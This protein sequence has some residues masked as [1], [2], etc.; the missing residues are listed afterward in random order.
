MSFPFLKK[1]PPEHTG[2][3]GAARSLF[4][5]IFLWFWLA[6][7]LSSV[8]I[9][10]LTVTAQ[11]GPIARFHKMI[12]SHRDRLVS[13]ALLM[14]GESAIEA[15]SRG[16]SPALRAMAAKVESSSGIRLYIFEGGGKALYG[17]G[18][19][20][21]K[22]EEA[23]AGLAARVFSLSHANGRMRTPRMSTPRMRTEVWHGRFLAALPFT[24]ENQAGHEYVIAAEWPYVPF[25]IFIKSRPI[26]PFL[27][28]F[29][30]MIYLI[31]GGGIC[32]VLA[33]QLT[34]PIRRLRQATQRLAAGDLKA[35]VGR[36]A[37]AAKKGDEIAALGRDFDSMAERMESLLGAQQRLIRDISHELRSP[38]ARLNVALE[39]ARRSAGGSAAGPL[40]RIGKEAERLN[41]L[42]AQL[43]T[44]TLLESGTESLEKTKVPVDLSEL[45][46]EIADD[47][48]YEASGTGRQVLVIT[49]EGA[50]V[51]GSPRMLRSAIENVVRNAVRYTPAGQAVEITLRRAAGDGGHHAVI[52][53]RDHGPG[54]P[55]AALA[56]LFKP[57]YRVEDARDRASGGAGVGLAIT[58]RAVHLHGGVVKASNAPDGGLVVEI[59]LP[60][61]AA[62]DLK[63]T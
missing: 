21:K 55:E 27:F 18:K 6:M 7:A 62:D 61:I 56:H 9:V 63:N 54:V 12:E 36:G 39:L 44:L 37:S 47:A 50:S 48:G 60:V 16:G 24:K 13:G 52:R 4:L 38:L 53:V 29:R 25:R 10:L 45:V 51:S 3:K 14:Y 2:G 17:G 57:F 43:V 35:R 22:S 33:W 8:V 20:Q 26:Y 42:I 41:D 11:I 46:A 49:L 15:Y 28:G 32:Y 58:E 31:V 19:E 34:A 1:A 23:L 30:Q 40:D 59:S 5:K